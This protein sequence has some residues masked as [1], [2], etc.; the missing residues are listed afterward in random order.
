MDGSR[1]DCL[2]GAPPGPE[3]GELLDD[4]TAL[5]AGAGVPPL[6]EGQALSGALEDALR[7]HG[8]AAPVDARTAERLTASLGDL[9]RT[10]RLMGVPV[11]RK[12]FQSLKARLSVP[13]SHVSV[14]EKCRSLLPRFVMVGPGTRLS[15]HVRLDL[16]REAERRPG[17]TPSFMD[18]CLLRYVGIAPDGTV[19]GSVGGPEGAAAV[20]PEDGTEGTGPSSFG[21]AA[22]AGELAPNRRRLAPGELRVFLNHAG[23]RL[24]RVMAGCLCQDKELF[25]ACRLAVVA[26]GPFLKVLAAD[27]DGVE[28]ELAQC[29]EGF[30]DMVSLFVAGLAE[31]GRGGAVLLLD[32]PGNRIGKLRSQGMWDGIGALGRRCLTVATTQPFFN[33]KM[34]G[35]QNS[36]RYVTRVLATKVTVVSKSA[37]SA[38]PGGAR[39]LQSSSGPD[40]PGNAGTPGATGG[41]G[42]HGAVPDAGSHGPEREPQVTEPAPG[43]AGPAR[44]SGDG[45]DSGGATGRADVHETA[46][47]T[48]EPVPEGICGGCPAGADLR[49]PSGFD[50]MESASDAGDP[51]P[52]CVSGGGPAGADVREPSGS[53]GRDPTPDTWDPVPAGVN[54]GGPAGDVREPS[55]DDGREPALDS[56]DPIPACAGIGSAGDNYSGPFIVQPGKTKCLV[57]EGYTDCLY[58]NAISKLVATAGKRGLGEDILL[59]PAH[60]VGKIGG[61]VKVSLAKGLRTAA[62]FDSDEAGELASSQDELVRLL[63]GTRILRMRDFYSWAVKD[64]EMEDLLRVTLVVVAKEEFGMDFRSESIKH[65]QVPISDVFCR[66]GKSQFR[67]TKLAAAF[68]KW[69]Q[70]RSLSSLTKRERTSCVSLTE[71]INRA[72]K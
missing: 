57:V 31:A 39:S 61:C 30:Q 55:G 66:I 53:N 46:R 52:A 5:A 21:P 4:V 48:G 49:E 28:I 11:D 12:R 71:A 3:L 44:S 69:A 17:V 25:G 29:P 6:A 33:I 9:I 65:N 68:A 10:G 45:C 15:P 18:R 19:E 14:L 70:R 38:D 72:L 32:D 60:S 50:G 23:V 20:G 26:D 37:V 1:W 34:P 47:I 36:L 64:V 43:A 27:S 54:G 41:T 13:L 22:G 63:D 62:L 8:S 67:K 58:L 16:G 24:T 56:G 35:G 2:L 7:L 42:S 40:P 59:F 51:V